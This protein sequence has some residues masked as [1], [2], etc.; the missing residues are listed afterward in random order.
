VKTQQRK[1]RREPELSGASEPKFIGSLRSQ[2]SI[3]E[4]WR[5]ERSLKTAKGNISLWERNL[6]T[7]QQGVTRNSAQIS[8]G[9]GY[10]HSVLEGYIEKVANAKQMIAAFEDQAVS[11]QKEIDALLPDAEKAAERAER[12]RVLAGQAR[13]RLVLDREL[14]SSLE[15]VRAILF[16][17]AALTRKMRDGAVSLEFDRNVNLDDGRFDALLGMLPREMAAESAKHVQWLL[18]EEDGRRPCTV[19]SDYVVFGETLRCNN[20]FRYDDCANLT[21]KEEDVI[22]RIAASRGPVAP[23]IETPPRRLGEPAA[24]VP[25]SKVQWAL[26]R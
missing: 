26:L 21:K 15:A 23:P 6:A 10:A 20:A 5:L 24:E 12:Q 2:K 14:D 11:L 22:E 7:A 4:Q 3:T 1:S 25:P 8:A 18:G 19:R 13:A 16:E 17:R 9:Q